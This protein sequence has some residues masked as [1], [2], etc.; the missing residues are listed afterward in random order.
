MEAIR[1]QN[2]SKCYKRINVV[3]N[4]TMSVPMGSIYGFIGKNGAGKSTTLK[5]LSG[6]AKP[7][8]GEVTLFGEQIGNEL[9]RHRVGTLIES[10]GVYPTYSAFENMMLKAYCFGVVDAKKICLEYLDLV[11][12]SS[13]KGKKVKQFSMGMKQRLG[14]AMALVGNPDLLL[15]D[16]PVNGLDPEGMMKVRE[17]L[18]RLNRER[19]ITM[20]VSSHILG[21]LSRIS[22]HYGIIK[23]GKLVLESDAESITEECQDYLKIV[24]NDVRQTSVILEQDMQIKKYNIHPDGEVHIFDKVDTGIINQVLS[25]KGIRVKELYRHHQ[26]LEDYFV[27]MMGGAENV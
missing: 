27:E 1:T 16:E 3:D 13:A 12:L 21:E 25:E 2:L 5:M 18:L 4:L 9:V 11:G 7:S 19:G 23:N 6:L 14:I 17:I 15:L 8:G 22:T 20:I 10:V 24:V 26:N